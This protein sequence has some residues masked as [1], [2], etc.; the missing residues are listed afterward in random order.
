[1]RFTCA[2]AENDIPALLPKHSSPSRDKENHSSL[3]Q[4]VRHQQGTMTSDCL[5]EDLNDLKK[6]GTI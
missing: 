4:R 2:S 1:M 5:N 3:G 6:L